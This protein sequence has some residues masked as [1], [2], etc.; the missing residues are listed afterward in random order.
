MHTVR[1]NI[2]LPED[3]LNEISR[4]VGPRKR[5]RFITQAIAR[6]LKELKDQKL[7]AEYEE[8]A[9]EISRIN[10]ELD[11]VTADGLD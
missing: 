1:V 3:L 9:A 5:S 7:A 4:E 11:G 10:Q 6:S 2:S 8:A